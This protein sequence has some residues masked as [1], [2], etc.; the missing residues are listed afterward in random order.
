VLA[1]AAWVRPD[2]RGYGTH[3]QI[4]HGPCLFRLLA[5]VPC[6]T[7]GMTTSFAHMARLQVKKA[8]IAQPFGVILF[9][10]VVALVPAGVYSVVTG[11]VPMVLAHPSWMVAPA[12][13]CLVAGWV[14]KILRDQLMR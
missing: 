14:F 6:P 7:C 8:A 13:A 11:R 9:V 12:L 1:L 5:G 2:P 3:T 10:I 4:T